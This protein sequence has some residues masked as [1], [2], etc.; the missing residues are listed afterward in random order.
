MKRGFS[1][2][3]SAALLF[4]VVGGGAKSVCRPSLAKDCC[5]KSAPAAPK[6]PCAQM[7]CCTAALPPTAVGGAPVVQSV[8][9]ALP[10]LPSPSANLAHLRV[11]AYPE[12]GPPDRNQ[13]TYAGRS[14]PFT[15]LG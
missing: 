2:L 6:T 5:G 11:D 8:A 4:S 3:L 7:L 10:A 14:P 1:G 13:E 15:R 9:F 12:C